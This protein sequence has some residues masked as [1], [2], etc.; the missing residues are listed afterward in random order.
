MTLTKHPT[1]ELS[2]SL[3]VG[4][5]EILG[6]FFILDGSFGF[7]SFIEDYSH[8]ST[9]TILVAVPL[10]VVAYV[11]GL[12]SSLAMEAT[13]GVLLPSKLTP[14]LFRAVSELKNDALMQRFLDAERHTL[15]LYGCS[16]AFLLLG[17]GSWV[18]VKMMG[19]FSFVGYMGFAGG[20]A[21]AISCPIIASR[22]Q[23]QAVVFTQAFHGAEGIPRI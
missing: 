18:E 1:E 13:L 23:T 7:L 21:I 20:I 9:W 17:I 19:Q 15:L 14:V 4:S 11:L 6:V 10:L 5:L 16:I 12:I 8:T 3:G 2:G 22:L